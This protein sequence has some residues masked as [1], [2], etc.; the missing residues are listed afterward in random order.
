MSCHR[1]KVQ[2]NHVWWKSNRWLLVGL[3]K[4]GERALLLDENRSA[5]V[6]VV[7]ETG[8]GDGGGGG[9]LGG[10]SDSLKDIWG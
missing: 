6:K 8:A 10:V 1:H 2:S 5:T 4:L 3:K 9:A 7:E